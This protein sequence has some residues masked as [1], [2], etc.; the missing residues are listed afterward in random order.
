[1]NIVSAFA[2]SLSLAADAMAV[3][4]CCGLKSRRN[5]RK[6]AVI[7]AALFGFFQMF[8]SVL[9]WSIGKVGVRLISGQEGIA[10]FIILL[11]LGIKMM[12]ESRKEPTSPL[13]VITGRELLLFAVA[14]SMDALAL[15][16]VLPVA[17]HADTPLSLTE[18]VLLIGAVTFLLSYGGFRFGHRFR[19]IQPRWA[20]FAGGCVLILLGGKILFWG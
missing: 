16:T 15:G 1:M 17:V 5:Y 8:M 2:V 10:A 11:L 4:V 13:A 7:T 9:G 6:T 3:A 19:S 14:T 20:V 12:M 18:A